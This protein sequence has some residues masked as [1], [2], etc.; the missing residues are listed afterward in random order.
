MNIVHGRKVGYGENNEGFQGPGSVFLD[1]AKMKKAA[2][3][4][5]FRA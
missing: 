5:G 3:K 1:A 4:L 2:R